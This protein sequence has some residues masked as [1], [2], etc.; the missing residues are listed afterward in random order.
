MSILFRHRN[1]LKSA[2][3]NLRFSDSLGG[4]ILSGFY[5]VQGTDILDITVTSLED[6]KNLLIT[7]TGVRI[8]ETQDLVDIL[9]LTPNTYPVPRIDSIYAKYVHGDKES[10]VEYVVVEGLEN[11]SPSFAESENT[12]TLIG[13]IHLPK[14][15]EDMSGVKYVYPERGLLLTDVASS[16]NFKKGIKLPAPVELTDGV[17]KRYVDDA[18]LEAS[19][20][21]PYSSVS[22]ESYNEDQR[23]FEV[24]TYKRGDGTTHMTTELSEPNDDGFFTTITLSRY[25]NRG[26]E[27]TGTELWTLTYDE[28][29]NTTSKYRV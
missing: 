24:V 22:S 9:T 20:G 11:G 5:F 25:D 12:H 27:V 28:F 2:E 19:E 7:K 13:Y 10:I 15:A 17:N 3:F 1:P 26:V 6:D 4:S 21:F 16:T 14:D 29:G 23:V 18:T 8:E